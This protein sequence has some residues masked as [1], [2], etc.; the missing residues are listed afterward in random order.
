MELFGSWC[1]SNVVSLR[2]TEKPDNCPQ[3]TLTELAQIFVNKIP[4]IKVSE[5]REKWV[6]FEVAKDV[7]HD[8]EGD[9]ARPPVS[10]PDAYRTRD[11]RCG[12][13]K[14]LKEGSTEYLH[15]I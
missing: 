12:Q 9:K 13:H 8:D 11:I 15:N 1:I 10:A 14:E 5:S 3:G 4:N 2:L 6:S 7:G